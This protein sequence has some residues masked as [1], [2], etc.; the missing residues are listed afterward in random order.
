MAN[1]DMAGTSTDNQTTGESSSNG[2]QGAG[3][4]QPPAEPAISPTPISPETKALI[5]KAIHDDRMKTGRE[6]R[7]FETAM[8]D[9]T[10]REAKIL[11]IEQENELAELEKVKDKPEELSIIQRRQKLAA[12]IRVHNAEIERFQTEKAQHTAELAEAKTGRFEMAISGIAEKNNVSVNVLKDWAAKRGITDLGLIEDYAS[13]MPKKTVVITPDS[14]KNAGG[15]E[16]ISRLSPRE[17][18]S[19]GLNKSK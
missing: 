11:K 3:I 6:S 9:I 8:A 19:R 15:G 16:D 10:A 2:P 4:Q 18:I 5:E 12:D 17:L 14:G 1:T 13:V 7:A